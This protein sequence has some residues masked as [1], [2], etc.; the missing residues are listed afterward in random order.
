MPQ[1][2]LLTNAS[3]LLLTGIFLVATGAIGVQCYTDNSSYK[4]KYPTNF[5][6]MITN[7][8][9]AVLMILISFSSMYMAFST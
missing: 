8:V 6:F 4:D 9:F 3:S 2:K 1:I 5:N 7:I